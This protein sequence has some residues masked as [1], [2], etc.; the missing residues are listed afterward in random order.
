MV[1]K[2]DDAGVYDNFFELGGHSLLA[3]QLVSRIREQFEIELSLRDFFTSPTV[4]G[5]AEVIE[6]NSDTQSG[7]QAAQIKRVSRLRPLPLSFAQQRLWFTDRLEPGTSAYN[8]PLAIRISGSLNIGVLRRTLSEVVQRH[9]VLRTTFAEIDGEPRQIIAPP[10]EVNLP[11]VDLCDLGIEEQEAALRFHL[12]EAA[13][14]QFDLSCGPLIKA[15]I[16][17]MAEDEYVLILTMHHIVTDEWSMGVLVN[18]VGTLYEAF[19]AGRESPLADL[20]IQ[21]ADY[22]VWQRKRLQGEVLEELLDY[23]RV[24]LAGAPSLELP[25]DYSRAAEQSFRSASVP[26]VLTPQ[27]TA[28]LNEIT[29]REGVTLFMTLL[30]CWQLLLARYTR[31]DDIVVGSPI[32][33]RTRAGVEGLIGFFVNI[34]VLRTNVSGELTFPELLGR[35]RE[36]CLGAYTHQDLP[37]E[38][39]V[40]EL[41]PERQWSRSPFFQVLFDLHNAPQQELKLPGLKLRALPIVLGAAKVD[42]TLSMA[43]SEGTLFGEFIYNQDLFSQ[44]IFRI[45]EQWLVLLESIVENPETPISALA[46]DTEQESAHA[47]ESFNQELE[48]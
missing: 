39:L 18:E 41:Q 4:S 2:I 8:V 32:A 35:V 40:E 30:A 3:T 47:I 26:F 25:T 42:L 20:P 45:K 22:A 43:E 7:A 14:Q 44:T 5:V 16:L 13:E 15:E 33:N 11:L 34:L 27:L 6:S 21:Y 29:R 38:R 24:Q 1:L 36:V 10:S 46:M 23:W 37:F 9:E 48:V 12:D 17:K 28:A 31:Q 19:A